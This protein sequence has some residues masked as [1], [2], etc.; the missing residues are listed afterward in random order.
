MPIFCVKSVKIYTGQKKFTRVYPW[1]PWQIWGMHHHKQQQQQHWYK[2]Q[3]HWYKQQQQWYREQQRDW[4]KEQQRD[5]YKQQQIKTQLDDNANTSTDNQT[6]GSCTAFL[7]CVF[8]CVPVLIFVIMRMLMILPVLVMVTVMWLMLMMCACNK[9]FDDIVCW[10]LIQQ[11]AKSCLRR[12]WNPKY[13][14]NLLY[15]V[16]HSSKAELA[17]W[18]LELLAN[19]ET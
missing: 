19:V 4:Y 5:W 6:K 9:S 12:K 10:W 17:C 16:R 11:F 8:S 1:L 15:F 18:P 14:L 13:G 2:Q 7:Q 3:Q